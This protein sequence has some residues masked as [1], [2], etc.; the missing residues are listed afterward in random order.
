ML[1]G[2]L[3]S[4]LYEAR[5]NLFRFDAWLHKLYTKVIE[6]GNYFFAELGA[7]RPKVVFLLNEHYTCLEDDISKLARKQVS[8]IAPAAYTPA[9]DT[10]VRDIRRDLILSIRDL[11]TIFE[12]LGEA[13]R[14]LKGFDIGGCAEENK[15]QAVE[16]LVQRWTSKDGEVE[17]IPLIQEIQAHLQKAEGQKDQIVQWR[18]SST[19]SR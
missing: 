6:A 7:N 15:M 18:L 5:E 10:A 12:T 19:Q 14:V 3:T 17:F 16:D 9:G 2:T 8:Q 11:N 4:K 13:G 1:P